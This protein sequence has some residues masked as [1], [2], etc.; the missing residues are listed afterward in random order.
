MFPD[1]SSVCTV[2]LF[3]ALSSVATVLIMG[4]AWVTTCLSLHSVAVYR[5]IQC[6]ECVDYGDSMSD[7]LPQFAQ[8]GCLSPYPVWR[9]CWLCGQHE[10]QLASVCTV[11]LFIALSSVATVLIMGTA[12][13]TTCLS[14]HSVAVYRP[15]QCGDCVDY[16]DSMSDNLPQFARKAAAE[17]VRATFVESP[18]FRAVCDTHDMCASC[19]ACEGRQLGAITVLCAQDGMIVFGMYRNTIKRTQRPKFWLLNSVLYQTVKPVQSTCW[20]YHYRKWDLLQAN[21]YFQVCKTYPLE[22]L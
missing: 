19:R 12:W 7:N 18:H 10:W 3:I 2:W 8:C 9:L 5:P 11:W 17:V 1:I 21:A 4:T 13:V 16:G 20:V 15:I 6:G 14:L 22:Y